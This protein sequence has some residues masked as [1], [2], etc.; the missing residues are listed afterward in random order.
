MTP[1]TPEESGSN[2]GRLLVANQ[3]RIYGYI[4]SAITDQSAVE[5]VLQETAAVI[6]EKS[7]EFRPGTNF[8]AWS[9]TIARLQIKKYYRLQQRDKLVFSDLFL[10]QVADST[11][12]QADQLSGMSDALLGCVGKLSEDDRKLLRDRYLGEQSTASIAKR[13]GRPYSTV[14]STL[15]NIRRRLADCIEKTLAREDP[16]NFVIRSGFRLN[17]K[18]F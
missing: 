11:A 2:V 7:S 14:Y 13:L 18:V 17:K 6:W 5:D 4:R 3:K 1:S 15:S 8:L 9:L 16:F 10:E 12:D